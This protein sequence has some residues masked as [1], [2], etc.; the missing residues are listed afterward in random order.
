M[1]IGIESGVFRLFSASFFSDTAIFCLRDYQSHV[2][3]AYP[4][5]PSVAKLANVT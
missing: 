5:L 4:E 2:F 3:R 1:Q